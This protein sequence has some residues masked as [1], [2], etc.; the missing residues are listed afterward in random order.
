MLHFSRLIAYPLDEQ[1]ERALVS[2]I[3]DQSPKGHSDWLARR[4]DNL[5]GKYIALGQHSGKLIRTMTPMG[6]AGV[7][8]LSGHQTETG[9]GQA[10]AFYS[11]L[12]V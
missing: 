3:W 12:F 1:R 7:G 2:G 4:W 6:Q 5:S 11:R 9:A 10:L 8:N